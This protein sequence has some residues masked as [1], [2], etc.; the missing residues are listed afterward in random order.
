L[1]VSTPPATAL[2]A[3]CASSLAT[4]VTRAI[5]ESPPLLL[6]ALLLF[7]AGLALDVPPARRVLTAD[8]L[9]VADLVDARFDSAGPV[10]EDRPL[11]D[12]P[13]RADR[14]ADALVPARVFFD[15]LRD[16][17]DFFA[18]AAM[19]VSSRE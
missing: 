7:A 11:A 16:L 2:V 12:F 13:P 19:A 14:R 6:L 5:G 3:W 9:A 15:L 18:R 4:R 1:I 17:E 10:A 8:R